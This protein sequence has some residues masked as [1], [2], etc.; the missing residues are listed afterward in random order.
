M[1]HPNADSVCSGRSSCFSDAGLGPC[2][3]QLYHTLVQRDDVSTQMYAV[4]IVEVLFLERRITLVFAI[5][6]DTY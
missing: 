5:H 2:G 1:P 6:Q 3:H 4:V